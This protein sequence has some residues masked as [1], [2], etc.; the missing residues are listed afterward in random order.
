[1]VDKGQSDVGARDVCDLLRIKHRSST[2][3]NEIGTVTVISI[4]KQNW[5]MKKKKSGAYFACDDVGN[6]IW[7]SSSLYENEEDWTRDFYSDHQ[8][9]GEDDERQDP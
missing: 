6:C 4:Y 3:R 2:E 5:W 7:G 8:F 1:L 9:C